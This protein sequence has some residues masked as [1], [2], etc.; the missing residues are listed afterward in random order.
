M[1]ASIKSLIKIP[2]LTPRNKDFCMEWSW[3]CMMT[4]MKTVLFTDE[5]HA[6]TWPRKK[7]IFFSCVKTRL[8]SYDL[9]SKSG[10]A[11]RVSGQFSSSGSRKRLVSSFPIIPPQIII[12]RPLCWLVSEE[13]S[14]Y[15][16]HHAISRPFHAKIFVPRC[17]RRYFNLTFDRSHYPNGMISCGL[18]SIWQPSFVKNYSACCS[19][20]SVYVFFNRFISRI[21]NKFKPP[22]SDR[23]FLFEG[24]F[25]KFLHSHLFL[26]SDSDLFFQ[27]LIYLFWLSLFLL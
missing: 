1:V 20:H 2:S 5:Y 27:Q 26:S 7:M 16:C 9:L 3:K 25:Q 24:F 8:P 19:R 15:V 13:N 23:G 4:N 11:I 12:T 21:E 14:L 10:W 18:C 22:R 17:Q 6:W